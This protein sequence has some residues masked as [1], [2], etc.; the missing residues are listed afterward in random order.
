MNTVSFEDTKLPAAYHSGPSRPTSIPLDQRYFIAWD[1]EGMNLRGPNRPQNY[2][3]FGA[4]TGDSISSRQLKTFEILDLI[5]DVGR[6][7]PAGIHV[8]FAFNYDTNMIVQSLSSTALT[9]LHRDGWINLN[10]KNGSR[11]RIAVR[12]GKSFQVTRFEPEWNPETNK[13]A[14]CTVTIFD[15]FTFFGVSFV[16]TAE[17]MLGKDIEG[18]DIVREGKAARKDFQYEDI[19]YVRKYW[20]AEIELVRLVAEELR[21][22]LYGAGLRI[23]EW[24]GPGALAS[25]ANKEHGTKEHMD[26]TSDEIRRAARY[27]YA[28]G[29]FELYKVGRVRG[30]VYGLDINSAYPF[31]IAQLPSL[32]GGY[33]QYVERP[34]NVQTFGV[35]RIRLAQHV[36]FDRPP[37]PLFHRDE[38]HNISYPWLVEGWYWSPEAAR[39]VHH[40]QAE[41]LEG[42]EFVHN[43]SEPFAWVRDVYGKRRLWQQQGNSSEWSLKLLLN[44]LYGKMAQRVGW[45]EKRGR[46]PPWHQ[47][48]WAGWVTSYC[49]SMLYNMI[50]RIPWDQL[51][52]VETDGIYTTMDPSSLGVTASKELGGWSV[53]VYDELVYIQSGLAWLRSGESWDS[54]RRGLDANT[55]TL[56]QCVEYTKSLQPGVRWDSYHGQQ[57]RFITLGAAVHQAN[58]D[59]GKL[60]GRHCVWRTTEKRVLPGEHGK[61]IHM[62]HLCSGCDSGATAWEAPHDLVIRSQSQVGVMSTQHSI[63]WEGKDN[64]EWRDY[65]QG[66]GEPYRD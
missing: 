38:R 31:A 56:S 22:R 12:A 36:G 55:F 49:R 26:I 1:G 14:R 27:A 10:R 17:A 54:K 44:S 34:T 62:P 58:G 11:Y 18:M 37:G 24:H 15:I 60:K 66:E 28:G 5:L 51:I 30:P 32:Q 25:Y 65:Q 8:G 13:N 42:W 3:L 7:N 4:S 46:I 61:R 2:V 6:R 50:R 23:R 41:L 40:P 48:E 45:D 47:L 9:M 39:M 59:G 64:A 57:T 29:R 33:W 52:A 19:G 63:P 43:E 53:D 20:D 16:K 35:Y 21:R